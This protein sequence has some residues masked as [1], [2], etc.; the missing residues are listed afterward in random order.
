[1]ARETGQETGKV[2]MQPQNCCCTP[3]SHSKAQDMAVWPEAECTEWLSSKEGMP[4][5]L[6]VCCQCTPSSA[7]E[8]EM[9]EASRSLCQCRN[10]QELNTRSNTQP[11]PRS[12]PAEKLSRRRAVTHKQNSHS[13]PLLLFRKLTLSLALLLSVCHTSLATDLSWSSWSIEDAVN[14]DVSQSSEGLIVPDLVA[15]AGRLFQY[16]IKFDANKTSS[17]FFQVC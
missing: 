13:S 2:S 10:C 3:P 1:M 11:H 17:L 9:G 12:T 16:Q 4:A 8:Y 15:V 14:G 5:R 6:C 7:I